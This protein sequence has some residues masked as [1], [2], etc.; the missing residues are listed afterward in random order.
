MAILLFPDPR[1]PRAG[2]GFSVRGGLLL[3]R[4]QQSKYDFAVYA[5]NRSTGRFFKQPA[6]AFIKTEGPRNWGANTAFGS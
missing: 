6:Q 5:A 1:K 4:A 2:S 3:E